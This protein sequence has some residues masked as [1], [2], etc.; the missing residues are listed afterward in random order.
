[1]KEKFDEIDTCNNILSAMADKIDVDELNEVSD[2]L[3]DEL[4]LLTCQCECDDK[5][6]E[7]VEKLTCQAIECMNLCA[8]KSTQNKIST[9]IIQVVVR[10]CELQRSMPLRRAKSDTPKFDKLSIAD[11]N[12]LDAG[13]FTITQEPKHLW[14]IADLF[15]LDKK[16]ILKR[17]GD[18]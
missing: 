5:W 2:Y 17:M 14:H 11:L 18:M 10:L 12:L 8:I 16:E 3:G 13:E 9:A 15:K 7:D 4:M 6:F 1:M